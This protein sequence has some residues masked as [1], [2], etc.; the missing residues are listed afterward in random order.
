MV[1]TETSQREI[2]ASRTALVKRTATATPPLR[3]PPAKSHRLAD[4]VSATATSVEPEIPSPKRNTHRCCNRYRSCPTASEEIVAE[5][6]QRDIRASRTALVKRTATATPTA[7]QQPRLRS[8]EPQRYC[9]RKQ[10]SEE[11][12]VKR[13]ATATPSALPDRSSEPHRN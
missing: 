11:A 13:T 9:Q 3:Q 7:S 10:A 6:N 4:E 1:T 8:S 5:T 12:L 2:R